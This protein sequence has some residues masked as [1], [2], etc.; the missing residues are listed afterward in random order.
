VKDANLQLTGATQNSSSFHFE[1]LR[2]NAPPRCNCNKC[3]YTIAHKNTEINPEELREV[4]LATE[5]RILAI[6]N[7][8]P[9]DV[10][11]L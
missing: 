5:V 8:N 7:H 6:T 4:I 9:F 11:Q 3:I 1:E 10:L 2:V